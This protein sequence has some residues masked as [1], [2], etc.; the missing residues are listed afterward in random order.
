MQNLLQNLLQEETDMITNR[1]ANGEKVFRPSAIAVLVVVFLYSLSPIDFIPE[2]LVKPVI[3]GFID[4]LIF[5]V[6]A[7]VYSAEDVSC[8]FSSEKPVDDLEDSIPIRSTII[9]REREIV[10]ENIGAD[11]PEENIPVVSMENYIRDMM[12]SS[13]QKLSDEEDDLC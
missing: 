1:R 13:S 11:L 9:P 3:F 5:I 10:S 7:I 4:D 6:A 12:S 2:L 8:L